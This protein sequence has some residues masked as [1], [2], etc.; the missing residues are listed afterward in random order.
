[1]GA[2]SRK[3]AGAFLKKCSRLKLVP[4]IIPHR[5]LNNQGKRSEVVGLYL[6]AGVF[7]LS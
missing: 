5:G 1:M 6:A 3:V 2:G 7:W 4:Y